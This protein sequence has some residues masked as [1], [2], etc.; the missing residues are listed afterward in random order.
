MCLCGRQRDDG[1][2]RTSWAGS[3]AKLSLEHVG[4]EK[5]LLR[6]ERW[7]IYHHSTEG[8]PK[9]RGQQMARPSVKETDRHRGDRGG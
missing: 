8:L 5:A 2:L 1:G 4:V 9:L 7:L 6:A 3:S